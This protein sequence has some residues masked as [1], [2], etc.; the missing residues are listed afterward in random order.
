MNRPKHSRDNDDDEW[1]KPWDGSA[2]DHNAKHS[3]SGNT[4]LNS[5][6]LGKR[7][8]AFYAPTLSGPKTTIVLGL[9]AKPT[10]TLPTQLDNQ[11]HIPGGKTNSSFSIVPRL[12]FPAKK[13]DLDAFGW[14]S[15][16][17]R[18]A[19]ATW[20]EGNFNKVQSENMLTACLAGT[21]ESGMSKL[22]SG[23]INGFLQ[24]LGS[25]IRDPTLVPSCVGRPVPT[26]SPKTSQRPILRLAAVTINGINYKLALREAVNTQTPTEWHEGQLYS[27]EELD[28]VL[29]S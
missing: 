22:L 26:F 8:D 25:V 20:I 10:P 11:D 27:K 29:V 4:Y 14:E 24:S 9:Y 17:K 7:I 12:Y 13:D 19:A 15:R 1:G 18:D 28:S 21:D 2:M 5:Y 6:Q 16:A 3:F 23:K